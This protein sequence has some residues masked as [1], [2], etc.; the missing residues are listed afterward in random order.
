MSIPSSGV[1]NPFAMAEAL[2][3]KK[4]RWADNPQ[5]QLEKAFGM[6]ISQLL[7]PTKGS[8]IYAGLNVSKTNVKFNS[9]F[10]DLK[11]LDEDS[12]FQKIKQGKIHGLSSKWVSSL[13][14]KKQKRL[15][16]L[17]RATQFAES[18]P[19]PPPPFVWKDPGSFYGSGGSSDKEVTDPVQGAIGDCYF[20]SAMCSVVWVKKSKIYRQTVSSNPDKN[21]VKFYAG[22]NPVYI[23]CTEKVPVAIA[24]D[25][26]VYARS[27]DN[28]EF[29]PSFYEK[30]YAKWKN[31]TSSDYPDYSVIHGGSPGGALTELTGVSNKAYNTNTATPHNVTTQIMVR[32]D[33]MTKKTLVPITATTFPSGSDYGG[34]NGIYAWHAYSVLGWMKEDSNFY[35]ILR[36]PWGKAGAKKY[37]PSATKW[38]LTTP[39]PN[40]TE[41]VIELNKNGI[42]GLREDK[43]NEW[44]SCI[45]YTTKAI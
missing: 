25:S 45:E 17:F 14:D 43:F 42:F 36:N 3:G 26:L 16:H 21:K 30:A 5:P 33:P 35:I 37:R 18:S 38:T 10:K 13:P 34:T 28:D 31:N 2:E 7:K 12:A 20:I 40:D 8:P 27:Y 41:T 44:F 39:D 32:C 1:I 19:T 22:S 11:S 6:P 23:T 4:I 24:T 29:Y 15:L 9:P